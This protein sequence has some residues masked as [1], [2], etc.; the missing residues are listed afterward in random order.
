[1]EKFRKESSEYGVKNRVHKDFHAACL[2]YLCIEGNLCNFFT[3][4]IAY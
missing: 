2:R 1:M 4:Y 3:I